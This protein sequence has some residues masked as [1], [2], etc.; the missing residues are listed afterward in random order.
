LQQHRR[1]QRASEEAN[2]ARP[3]EQAKRRA[4]PGYKGRKKERCKEENGDQQAIAQPEEAKQLSAY[5]TPFSCRISR[6]CAGAYAAEVLVLRLRLR[7][8]IHPEVFIFPLKETE[9]IGITYH[10]AEKKVKMKSSRKI[11][12]KAA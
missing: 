3:G 6:S 7:W 8:I 4:L 5:L 10:T 9:F 11:W 1:K 2:C 12:Q